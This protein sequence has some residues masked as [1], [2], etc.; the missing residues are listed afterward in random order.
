MLLCHQRTKSSMVVEL[1]E[2]GML[3][4]LIKSGMAGMQ[5]SYNLHSCLSEQF[6]SFPLEQSPSGQ[7]LVSASLRLAV[8]VCHKPRLLHPSNDVCMQAIRY[9]Y[10]QP[11]C[12][13]ISAAQPGRGENLHE[14]GSP[15]ERVPA[16]AAEYILL[17]SPKDSYYHHNAVARQLDLLSLRN[18]PSKP[19]L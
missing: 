14:G 2:S 17:F 9:S 5:H 3:S 12:W 18:M 11:G 1:F 13:R 15:R 8:A 7:N 6:A 16:Q 19:R 10:Y 4:D